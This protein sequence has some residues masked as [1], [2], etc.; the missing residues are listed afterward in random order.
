MTTIL[1]FLT[2]CFACIIFILFAIPWAWCLFG[3]M[4]YGV[5]WGIAAYFVY[6]MCTTTREPLYEET[7]WLDWR[8]KDVDDYLN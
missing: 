8:I 7:G 5:L 4:R 2:H 3:V 6:L 1:R